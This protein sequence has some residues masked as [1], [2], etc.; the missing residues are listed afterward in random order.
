MS[1]KLYRLDVECPEC[2]RRPNRRVTEAG[3]RGYQSMPPNEIIESVICG[4]FHGGRVCRKLYWIRARAW[5]NA[6]QVEEVYTGASGQVD[7]PDAVRLSERQRQVCAL[8]V[9]GRT[10]SGIA[11]TLAISVWTVRE[12]MERAAKAIRAGE[13]GL[14]PGSP[15]QTVQAYF[16]KRS[17][18]SLFSLPAAA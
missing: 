14:R 17:D 12:Q 13:P 6:V 15:R 1:L 3:L 18:S 5:K 9:A 2:D 4:L 10:D 8:V 16:E 11:L 7:A